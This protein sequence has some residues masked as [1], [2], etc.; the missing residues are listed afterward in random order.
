MLKKKTTP[1]KLCESKVVSTH[2][3][4]T[5]PE[6]QPLPTGQK[7]WDP[8]FIV[9]VAGG[10]TPTFNLMAVNFNCLT[11]SRPLLWWLHPVNGRKA[12][13]VVESLGNP[14][15]FF[16]VFSEKWGVGGGEDSYYI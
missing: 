12:L 14:R 5:H 8:G 10:G 3:T 16:F 11:A 4:G 9:G 15:V 1:Q 7:N 2:R 6:T 13:N